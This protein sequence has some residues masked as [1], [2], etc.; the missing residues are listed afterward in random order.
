[1]CVECGA[2]GSPLQEEHLLENLKILK[3]FLSPSAQRARTKIDFFCGGGPAI[4]VRGATT[5]QSK[6]WVSNEL[7][8][9]WKYSD[10]PFMERAYFGGGV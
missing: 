5:G 4:Y 2:D 8:P 7:K 9:P 10:G 6:V 3:T 1:M